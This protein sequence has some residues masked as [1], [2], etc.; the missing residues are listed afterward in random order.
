M[1]VPL[2]VYIIVLGGNNS[3]WMTS[4]INTVANLAKILPDADI[5]AT[6]FNNEAQ[7]IK[8][9]LREVWINNTIHLEINARNTVENAI[10]TRQ[11]FR[12]LGLKNPDTIFLVT[13]DFHLHRA[14]IIFKD[15]FKRLFP[16]VKFIMVGAPSDSKEIVVR[17]N[18]EADQIRRM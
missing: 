4:R 8:N 16:R 15:Q 11:L 18:A 2:V 12:D 13:S 10:F 17:Y 5:I 9:S 14:S 3:D 1:N 7:N 6:G